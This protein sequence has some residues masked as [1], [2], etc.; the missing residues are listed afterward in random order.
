MSKVAY[1]TY[2]YQHLLELTGGPQVKDAAVR[3]EERIAS[4]YGMRHAFL[5]GDVHHALLAVALVADIR[6][7]DEVIV[8]PIEAR[9]VAALSLRGATLVPGILRSPDLLIDDIWLHDL[10]SERTRMV[11]V[12]NT[13]GVVVDHDAI[14]RGLDAAHEV[15]VVGLTSLG[16]SDQRGMPS[17]ADADLVIVD[18]GP[19]K[20]I[21]AGQGAVIV[22]DDQSLYERLLRVVAPIE[23]QWHELGDASPCNLNST[24][25]ACA[26]LMLHNTWD[27]QWDRLRDKQR[28]Y[29]KALSTLD[30]DFITWPFTRA[31]GCSFEDAWLC[32]RPRG[33]S[34]A[35]RCT[36]RYLHEEPGP[37]LPEIRWR[38]PSRTTAMLGI[39]KRQ[40]HHVKADNLIAE[41][42]LYC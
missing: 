5:V 19:G 33:S 1:L 12:P 41:Q 18:L 23:R 27:H 4:H 21:T 42:W 32:L 17:G 8:S 28:R 10:L 2:P 25:P 30:K 40:Y 6:R 37:H 11:V 9:G 13:G 29:A 24:L 38:V 20:A 15:L 35:E 22:L 3:L 16:A 26:S 14:R 34:S 36:L 39:L 7:G 31:G